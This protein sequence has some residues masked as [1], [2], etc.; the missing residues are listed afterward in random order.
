M[1]DGFRLAAFTMSTMTLGAVGWYGTAGVS[2]DTGQQEQVEAASEEVKNP[3]A[4][5]TGEGPSGP[6]FFGIAI[7][8]VKTLIALVQLTYK[9]Y[10][11][12]VSWSVPWPVALSV[13]MMVDLT[14]GV[15]LLIAF[16][17]FNFLRN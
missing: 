13:Q 16:R 4:E 11:I 6:G 17:G 14:V 2:F 12:L 3:E 15:S 5:A 7:G 8:S 9:T 10:P 1:A